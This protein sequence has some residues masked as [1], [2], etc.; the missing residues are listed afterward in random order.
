[1]SIEIR[2]AQNKFDYARCVQVRTIVFTI[3][4]NVPPDREID[5]EED[6]AIHFLALVDNVVMGAGRWRRYNAHSA[7]IERL[8]VLDIGR[9]KGIGKALM[10]GILADIRKTD[11]IRDVILGAQDHA[12]PF[13]GSL[14]FVIYGD[15]Y[16]DGGNIPH[17]DMRLVLQNEEAA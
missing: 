2:K 3:G 9:G 11:D 14:G 13:Y 5:P 16:M 6:N 1:M 7:K 10:Q 8:A 15:A 4:Q 12:I 17:R